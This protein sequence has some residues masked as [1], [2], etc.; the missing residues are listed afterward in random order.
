MSILHVYVPLS[1]PE[2]QADHLPF[3]LSSLQEQPISTHPVLSSSP[4][5][6]LPAGSGEGEVT[7]PRTVAGAVVTDWMPVLG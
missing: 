4:T 1:L 2:G 5:L 3:L 7:K 6:H